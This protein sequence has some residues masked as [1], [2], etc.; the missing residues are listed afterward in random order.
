[1][2]ATLTKLEA[3]QQAMHSRQRFSDLQKRRLN[4]LREASAEKDLLSLGVED[5]MAEIISQELKDK[6]Y[7]FWFDA[8]GEDGDLYIVDLNSRQGAR[9]LVQALKASSP[10]VADGLKLNKAQGRWAIYN[11]LDSQWTQYRTLR[12]VHKAWDDP[13]VPW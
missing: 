13:S 5:W 1:M 3:R 11:V 6:G 8:Q 12:D 4:S 2:P 9:F 7:S 10:E